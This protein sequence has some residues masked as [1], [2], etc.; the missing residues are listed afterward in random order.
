MHH[1]EFEYILTFPDNPN[2]TMEALLFFLYFFFNKFLPKYI[3]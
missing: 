3:W 1:F 2:Q